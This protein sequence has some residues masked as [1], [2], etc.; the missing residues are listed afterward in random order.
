[1]LSVLARVDWDKVGKAVIKQQS[2]REC[3]TP[4]VSMFRWW[5]RRPHALI[6]EILNSAAKVQGK[7]E[8]RVSDPFS[9]G[10]TVAFEAVRRGLPVYAQDLYPWPT[11]GLAVALSR[12]S[13]DEFSAS[14]SRLLKD[15][16][17]LR[18]L[19]RRPD[20]R[21]LTHILRVRLGSCPHCIKAI[22]LFPYP[23]ISLVSRN[24]D[25][26]RAL[27]GCRSCGSV[28]VGLRAGAVWKCTTC[29]HSEKKSGNK[30]GVSPC[31]HCG[32]EGRPRGFLTGDPDW[33]PVAVQELTMVRGRPRALLRPVNRR[34]P[35]DS[36]SA[37]KSV[38]GMGKQIP[39]GIETHRLV[40]S[41]LSAWGDLYTKRQAEVL[42]SALRL[43]RALE[44]SEACKDR[45]AMA[46]IGAAEMPAYLS[47]WDRFHLKA[48]EGLAN[49]RYSDT[50]LVVETNLLSPVGRGTIPHRLESAGKALDWT[51]REVV[52]S[53]RVKQLPKVRGRM[54]LTRRVIVATGNSARQ[55]LK[56]G[57]VDLVLTDPPYFNYVQY[58]ELA[59]LFHFWLSKYRQLPVF[60]ENEEA[61]PNKYRGNGQ[62]FYVRSIAAC[63]KECRRTLVPG[64]RLILTYHNKKMIAW[65]ALCAALVRAR[66]TVRSLAVIRA[67]NEADHGKR[68][69]KGM[70]QD[71]VLE[72]VRRGEWKSR[73]AIACNGHSAEDHGLLAMG[74]ALAKAVRI[75]A[76]ETLPNLYRA[77]LKKH[78]IRETSIR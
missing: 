55:G 47:R 72:C 75:G 29:G 58:G 5:A 4:V 21:E 15:L 61:V 10:G 62:E 65:R 78:G 9:G 33:R 26:K 3:H 39:D 46:V 69:G 18:S 67:E 63:L 43:I 59:R 32:F 17:P 30:V 31:P 66:L 38:L 50:T 51:L 27:Y 42:V 49:H 13:K 19:Y 8:L 77:E 68:N 1:M 41:G 34:D 57:T 24:S 16:S 36:L 70:L 44:A 48:F 73:T 60:E 71:L 54:E 53:I 56:N 6:G 22:Y 14:V 11:T 40:K 45:L 2:N 28:R 37:S 12:C 64:G 25:E 7:R 52:P 35:V 76:T 23:L 74:I 20:G